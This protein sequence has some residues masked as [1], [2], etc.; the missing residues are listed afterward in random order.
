[1]VPDARPDTVSEGPDGKRRNGYLRGCAIN[2]AISHAERVQSSLSSFAPLAYF[3]P[4]LR[5]FGECRLSE[6]RYP[7]QAQETYR[8]AKLPRVATWP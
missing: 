1:M 8:R 2:C 6:N 5:Q 7:I 3:R 4:Y